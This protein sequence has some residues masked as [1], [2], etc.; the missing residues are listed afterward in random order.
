MT[1][2]L[3]GT[4][5]VS[6][7][8]GSAS[9]P[10]IQGNDTNTGVFFPAADTVA[11]ATGGTERVRVDSSGNVGVG[12]SSPS[13]LVHAAGNV[14]GSITVASN[15]T[16][17]GA[18]AFSRF[19]AL[20]DAGNAQF[21]MTSSGYTDITGAQDAMLL[22]ANSASGGIAFALDG[23]LKAKIDSSGNLLVGGTS[24]DPNPG[25]FIYKSGAVSQ[26]NSAGGSG[27]EFVSFRR[28]GTQIGT[29]TQNG[30]TAVAY[31]TTSDYRLKENVQPLTGALARVAALKPVT[32]TWKSAPD[33]IGE[34][35]IAH[36]LAE[37]CPQAVTGEKDAVNEDGSIKAQSIDTSFLV[38]T[39]TAAIQ[40]LNAKVES[41]TAE[42]A[43]L[44]GAQA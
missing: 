17:A 11:V 40:E 41:L 1:L 14:N 34:G 26:G 20:A 43:T 8:D 24:G 19:L 7:V 38:A 29:I 2:V 25:V 12:T 42:I 9:T 39:L 10:A 35:F 31:N 33:E 30:T 22:N 4:T 44:K 28:S 36:E 13:H 6:A 32:Y 5:G 16:N 23:V 21:G 37:V 18:S 27:F 15:N 3:N